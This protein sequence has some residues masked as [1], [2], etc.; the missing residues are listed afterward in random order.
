MIR[1]YLL[2]FALLLCAMSTFA[3]K[4]PDPSDYNITVHVTASRVDGCIRELDAVI[5]GVNYQLTAA[6]D[7]IPISVG[8]LKLGD[9]KAKLVK[10]DRSSAF[11]ILQ[12]YEFLFPDNAKK[13]F[14]VVGVSQ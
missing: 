5:N 7:K 1:K 3:A 14:D 10:D 13:K 6:C 8:V 2:L 9:Y 12:S 4:K 11:Y